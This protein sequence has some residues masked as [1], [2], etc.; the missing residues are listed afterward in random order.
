MG[1]ML[2]NTANHTHPHSEYHY[3][4][5]LIPTRGLLLLLA[6]GID[7]HFLNLFVWQ[8]IGID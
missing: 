1:S 2:P 5:N 7:R 3:N 8:A 4:N 6:I